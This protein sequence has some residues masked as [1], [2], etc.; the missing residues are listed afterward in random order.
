MVDGPLGSHGFGRKSLWQTAGEIHVASILKHGHRESLTGALVRGC[1]ERH[2]LEVG[3][4]TPILNADFTTYGSLATTSWLKT[5][6]EYLD[7]IDAIIK[8]KHSPLV[9]QRAHDEFIMDAFVRCNTTPVNLRKANRCRLYLQVLTVADITTGDGRELTVSAINGVKEECQTSLDWPYQPKP[10][11]ED[12]KVWRETLTKALRPPDTGESLSRKLHKPLGD[13]LVDDAEQHKANW[14]YSPL[15][16]RLYQRNGTSW[17]PWAP[18]NRTSQRSTYRRWTPREGTTAALPGDAKRTKI[19]SFAEQSVWTSGWAN[20]TTRLSDPRDN[21][22]TPDANLLQRM[23]SGPR[24]RRWATENCI[25]EDNGEKLADGI[26]KGS[27][28]AISDGS[29]KDELATAASILLGEATVGFPGRIT[30]LCV[31]PGGP[32]CASAYRGE[33]SGLFSSLCT[34]EYVCNLHRI[35]SGKVTI[36]CDNE[37]GLWKSVLYHQDPDTATSD[38]D[39]IS[40]IRAKIRSLP[41]TVE[42]HWIKGH[43][44]DYVMIQHLDFWARTNIVCDALAK[45]FWEVK[46]VAAEEI[47][48]E[49]EGE[50][51]A[52]YLGPQ[53]V[54]RK[55]PDRLYDW[56]AGKTA[57]DYWLRKRKISEQSAPYIDWTVVKTA[58]ASLGFGMKLWKMKHLTERCPCGKN[59]KRW[60]LWTESTCPLCEDEEEDVDHLYRCSAL[61]DAWPDA[62]EPLCDWLRKARTDRDI[63]DTI[64]D[65]ICSWRRDEEPRM[66]RDNL[67]PDLAE[68]AREQDSI[69]WRNFIDGFVSHKW[70]S[71]IEA[72]RQA[73]GSR[74]RGK[75]WAVGIIRQLWQLSRDV[76]DHRNEV[77]HEGEDSMTAQATEELRAAVIE[78]FEKGRD[79][80]PSR[81][82]LHLFQGTIAELLSKPM[83]VQRA[84]L[85]GVLTAR[86]RHIRRT[87]GEITDGLQASRRVMMNWVFTRRSTNR[88]RLSASR[89]RRRRATM[90]DRHSRAIQ[91]QEAAGPDQREPD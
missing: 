56:A 51:P 76:W 75:S 12:W 87:G 34:V 52:L 43:Q 57:Q 89:R 86:E 17:N 63:I 54:S 59:M 23:R 44:D 36:A 73:S 38:F 15:E 9:A 84:W 48:W 33:L 82:A 88:S 83:V 29:F 2:Q 74:R 53:K 13:W 30:T 27:A 65:G 42:G 55:V 68:A 69:G 46:A 10:P 24:S 21:Q 31:A 7:D 40:A 45:S 47:Q 71:T 4:G 25:L 18:V 8:L 11:A 72:R 41:I 20:S 5:L 62:I 58:T 60:K 79:G 77:A 32:S 22:A 85:H 37:T 35:T 3:T 70:R 64:V 91:L 67:S 66:C 90:E 14:Y 19:S 61:D 16:D 81:L 6:W 39:L 78:Q 49:I 1:L 80:I 26:R 50:M 28:V